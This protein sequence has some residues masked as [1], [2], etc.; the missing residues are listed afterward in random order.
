[1]L[2]QARAELDKDGYQ[3]H[4]GPCRSNSRLQLALIARQ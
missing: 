1:L 4:P 2:L 3:L